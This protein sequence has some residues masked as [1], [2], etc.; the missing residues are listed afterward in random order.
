MDLRHARGSSHRR[1]GRGG[2]AR[3]HERAGMVLGHGLRLRGGRSG[4]E[5]R[6]GPGLRMG[7]HHVVAHQ[8]CGFG[9]GLHGGQHWGRGGS[10]GDRDVSGR[11]LSQRCL[12]ADRRDRL[13]SG[14]AG[15]SLGAQAFGDFGDALLGLGNGRVVRRVRRDQGRLD[16][17]GDH[18]DADDAVEALVEGGAQDDVGVLIDLFTDAG[19]G[20]VEFVEGQVRSA[21]DRD[22][23]A[24][25]TLHRDIVEERIRYGRLG[26]AVGALLAGGL[27]SSHHRLAHAAHDRAHV[28]EIEVDQAL[29]HHQV[30]DAGDARVEHLIGHREGVGEGGLLVGDPE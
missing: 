2:R 8:G 17:G 22:Q 4:H 18:R 10:R 12:G 24:A 5:G 19:R 7:Q 25:R 14:G 20:L 1:G 9:S 11:G 29:L 28:G 3:R 26:R 16:A 15:A 13:T 6:C 27:A 21:G 23:Q 30:G